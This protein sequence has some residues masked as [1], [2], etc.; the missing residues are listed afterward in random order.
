MVWPQ[1]WHSA[2][3]CSIIAMYIF[4]KCLIIDVI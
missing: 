2:V 4:Y 1:F 3:A